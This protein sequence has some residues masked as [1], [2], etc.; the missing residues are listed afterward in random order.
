MHTLKCITPQTDIFSFDHV[1]HNGLF[2]SVTEPYILEDENSQ[3][4]IPCTHMYFLDK[5]GT[6]KSNLFKGKFRREIMDNGN[7]NA[8]IAGVHSDNFIFDPIS[9]QYFTVLPIDDF[10]FFEY[11]SDRNSLPNDIPVVFKADDGF[12]WAKNN[13]PT[14]IREKEFVKQVEQRRNK[15]GLYGSLPLNLE[16]ETGDID[17]LL[18]GKNGF[19]SVSTYFMNTDN[20]KRMGLTVPQN[21]KQS[22]IDKYI[23]RFGVDRGLAEKIISEKPKGIT[24]IETII[25]FDATGQLEPTDEIYTI[26]QTKKLS[27]IIGTGT[28]VNN[29]RSC[30]FPRAYIIKF[31]SF[32]KR[33]PVITHRWAALKSINVGANVELS[34]NLRQNE[35][36]E[37]QIFLETK[38]HY[39]LPTL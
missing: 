32:D 30:F 15:L 21:Y 23:K 16:S 27:E 11:D 6:R 26:L 29:D 14:L 4:H 38:D 10:E 33:I 31:D 7:T 37:R 18:Y 39:I 8:P 13:S 24:E 22:L 36:G 28:V 3:S 9:Q 20:M 25:S 1:Y 5:S 12:E 2:G 17:F 19:D 34:G 35:N